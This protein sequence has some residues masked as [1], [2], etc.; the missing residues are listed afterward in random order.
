MTC[1]SGDKKQETDIS[2]PTKIEQSIKAVESFERKMN[3]ELRKPEKDWNYSVE[4]VE[5]SSDNENPS[6]STNDKP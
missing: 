6:T 1:I 5:N 4:K 3:S 2:L